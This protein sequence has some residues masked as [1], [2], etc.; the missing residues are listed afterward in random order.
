MKLN[1]IPDCGNQR[2]AKWMI[3]EVKTAK[4]SANEIQAQI[5]PIGT[6]HTD[7]PPAT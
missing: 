5:L 4:F 1:A 7:C 6:F 3:A 2:P